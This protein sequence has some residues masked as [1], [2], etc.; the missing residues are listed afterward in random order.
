MAQN[1]KGRPMKVVHVTET[2]CIRL[3]KEVIAL[4]NEGINTVIVC[5]QVGAPDLI[6]IM[7]PLRFYNFR[8]FEQASFVINEENP[9]VIHVHSEPAGLLSVLGCYRSPLRKKKFVLDLHDSVTLSAASD[10]IAKED[11]LKA[12]T[13]DFK[14]ADAIIVPSNAYSDSYSRIFRD[15]KAVLVRSLALDVPQQ[16][17]LTKLTGLAYWGGLTVDGWRDYKRLFTIFGDIGWPVYAYAPGAEGLRDYYDDSGCVLRHC[18]YFDLMRQ[19]SRHSIA[20]ICPPIENEPRW[21]S[22]LPNKYW[23]AIAIGMPVLSLGC[24]EVGTDL[25]RNGGGWYMP[26]EDAAITWLSQAR[27]SGKGLSVR[28]RTSRPTWASEIRPLVSTYQQLTGLIGAGVGLSI[29]NARG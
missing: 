12:E 4:R 5:A 24:P 22:A 20:L 14:R 9:D 13:E 21:Q 19:V 10:W 29:D 15:K 8:N 27:L 2:V 26:T 23:E 6:S 1:E 7:G 18:G 3:V 28:P 25:A 11:T 17:D 16:K